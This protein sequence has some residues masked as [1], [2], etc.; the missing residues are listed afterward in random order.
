MAGQRCSEPAAEERSACCS[1]ACGLQVRIPFGPMAGGRI[2]RLDEWHHF[3]R[4][5][6]CARTAHEGRGLSPLPRSCVSGRPRAALVGQLLRTCRARQDGPQNRTKAQTGLRQLP[7]PLISLRPDQ[8][9]LGGLGRSD[10]GTASAARRARP[11]I[12]NDG[13]LS[14]S[15]E[16]EAV[17]PGHT[18]A[19][20]LLSL[21]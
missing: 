14:N 4:R 6:C 3:D 18:Q 10:G 13:I 19:A 11:C 1:L 16:C 7:E 17:K 2:A 5:C 9:A 20:C 12:P 8:A 15:S 21:Q